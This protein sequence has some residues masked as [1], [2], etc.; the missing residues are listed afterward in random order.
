MS[1]YIIEYKLRWVEF[2]AHERWYVLAPN[3]ETAVK[4]F[5]NHFSKN[6]Y[7]IVEVAKVIKKD[8]KNL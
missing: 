6:D 8:F 5:R 2:S 1:D 3:V 7:E 4:M